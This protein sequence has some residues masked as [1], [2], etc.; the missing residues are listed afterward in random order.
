RVHLRVVRGWEGGGGAGDAPERSTGHRLTG[1]ADWATRPQTVVAREIG[2][3]EQTAD[4]R[5]LI[6]H[7]HH[8]PD[9]RG[10]HLEVHFERG[11]EWPSGEPAHADGSGGADR[12]ALR[13][14][15]VEIALIPLHLE[16]Q[17]ILEPLA[18]PAI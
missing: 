17:Q 6:E 2:D 13:V 14:A 18:R 8:Q 10:G 16:M 7:L 15:G 1:N 12:L 5:A 3:V 11:Q 9:R 4:H